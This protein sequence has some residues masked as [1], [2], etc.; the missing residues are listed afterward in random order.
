M[1]TFWSAWI[2]GL[3]L[4]SIFALFVILHWTRK[5]SG[6]TNPDETTGH[7]YDGIEEYNKPLPLWWLYLFYAT[8]IFALGYLIYYPIGN[9]KGIGGWTQINQLEAEQAAHAEKY[10]QQFQDYL[11]TD[12]AILATDPKAVKT[13]RDLFEQN[14]SLCHGTA[15][16]GGYGFPNL[17]DT[18]WLYG[19][20]AEAIKA[21]IAD[22]RRGQMPA[23]GESLGSKGV[24]QVTEYV[25]SLSQPDEADADK[26]K[27]G[28]AVFTQFCSACHGNDA[29]GNVAFGAPDLTDNI[30]LY[31]IPGKD[32]RFDIKTTIDKGRAGNMPAW[33]PIIGEEKVHLISAY[34]FSLTKEQ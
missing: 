10:G 16:T 32:L 1:S 29:K 28:E 33:T 9:W 27:V 5:M 2:I 34:V 12:V 25:L 30:W 18:D 24:S 17:T 15:A 21:S 4:F 19:G 8:L 23:W 14:C 3:T 7:V 22:G 20:S 13:G 31:D 26:A 11:E 6:G